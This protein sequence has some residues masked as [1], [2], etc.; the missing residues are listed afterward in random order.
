[1]FSAMAVVGT[2]AA[3]GWWL[4]YSSPVLSFESGRIYS[5]EREIVH[6]VLGQNQ[7]LVEE[8]D[9]DVL[10]AVDPCEGKCR[11]GQVCQ[12]S[13]GVAMCVCIPSCPEEADPRRKV[14]SNLNITYDSDCAIHQMRCWCRSSDRKCVGDKEKLSHIHIDYYGECRQHDECTENQMAD[15]P[16][17]MRDWLFNIMRD[18][19]DREELSPHYLRMEREA[20]TN[21]TK[22]WVNAAIW[23]FCDLDTSND[24]TISRH[25]VFPIRA[26]LI[27]LE[28]CIAP[29]LDK[30]DADGN[31]R[32]TMQEWASCLEI[33]EDEI[34][35]QCDIVRD[36]NDEE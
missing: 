18:S 21:L 33:K 22:R 14:C 11:S 31:H 30:C 36:E 19:A 23:K 2:K 29:F 10:E 5:K 27:A 7:P 32:I 20:E 9:P 24:R 35:D 25:E 34:E 17:R 6:P 16:R 12:L 26:P 15:F 1:M 13:E 4:E 8:E 28:H 3:S